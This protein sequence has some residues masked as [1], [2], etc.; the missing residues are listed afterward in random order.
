M[1][2]CVGNGPHSHRHPRGSATAPGREGGSWEALPEER[3][4]Q[5]QPPRRLS[6]GRAHQQCPRDSPSTAGL[7]RAL[8]PAP[9]AAPWERLL[10]PQ[11]P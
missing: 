7:G 8:L 4:D 3:H 11:T 9:T 5:S 1:V 10:H 6:W 2:S